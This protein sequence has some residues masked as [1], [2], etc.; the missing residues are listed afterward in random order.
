MFHPTIT[1]Y[2]Y[3]EAQPLCPNYPLANVPN[4]F[5]TNYPLASVPYLFIKNCPLASVPNLL[6]KSPTCQCSQL[7]HTKHLLACVPALL[8][9]NHPV[10]SVLNFLI[11]YNPF[12]Y[13]NSSSCQCSHVT[14]C[15]LFNH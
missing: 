14:G 5:I 10:A 15:L 3:L 2:R 9:T 11:I 7:P 4:L 12:P 1:L 8:I 6:I 13:H